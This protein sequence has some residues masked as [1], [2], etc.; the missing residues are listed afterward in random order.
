[1]IPD[2]LARDG[3]VFSALD[4]FQHAEQAGGGADRGARIDRV[5]DL[6]AAFALLGA[7]DIND[8]IQSNALP[9]PARVLVPGEDIVAG[10]RLRVEG[11]DEIAI[12]QRM[13]ERG[14]GPVQAGIGLLQFFARI[15]RSIEH[16][17]SLGRIAGQD[18]GFA[19]V[20]HLALDLAGEVAADMDGDL[21][22]L[23]AAVDEEGWE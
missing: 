9:I 19:T 12:D 15:E 21:L 7:G 5:Q 8:H 1:M 18:D 10:Q 13:T 6:L 3:V 20:A 23:G 4:I 11:S 14:R 22:I 2:D 17:V 16:G